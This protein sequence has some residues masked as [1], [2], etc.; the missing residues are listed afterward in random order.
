MHRT[1]FS[2]RPSRLKVTVEL[3]FVNVKEVVASRNK[4]RAT[5]LRVTCIAASIFFFNENDAAVQ[6]YDL[7]RSIVDRIFIISVMRWPVICLQNIY[8]TVSLHFMARDGSKSTG[9]CKV[10]SSRENRCL[11]FCGDFGREYIIVW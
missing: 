3:L 6:Q 10:V 7:T 8:S 2:L 1:I 4:R 9:R 5:W 11:E